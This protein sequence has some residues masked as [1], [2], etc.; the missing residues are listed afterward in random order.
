[1]L[2]DPLRLW[3]PLHG[4]PPPPLSPATSWSPRQGLVLRILRSNIQ[5]SNLQILD[6]A[7]WTTQPAKTILLTIYSENEGLS[8]LWLRGFGEKPSCNTGKAIWGLFLEWDA[9]VEEM[10]QVGGRVGQLHGRVALPDGKVVEWITWNSCWAGEHFSTRTHLISSPNK[11]FVNPPSSFRTHYNFF[12]TD[13][14]KENCVLWRVFTIQELIVVSVCFNLLL[15]LF[16]ICAFKSNFSARLCT[17]Q[18][19][20]TIDIFF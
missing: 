15:V 14:L 6:Y 1:M 3:L 12:D 17:K 4:S 18:L 2:W 11:L 9:H 7:S 16:F 5:S 8:F 13:F 19:K 10:N 20:G